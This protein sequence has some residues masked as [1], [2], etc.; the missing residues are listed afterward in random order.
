MRTLTCVV[1]DPPPLQG[2]PGPCG[3]AWRS[4][5][6]GPDA[7]WG[8]GAS[9]TPGCLPTRGLLPQLLEVQSRRPL[10]LWSR[11]HAGPQGT[12]GA[13]PARQAGDLS[14]P[15]EEAHLRGARRA[16]LRS[17]RDPCST[18]S[19]QRTNRLPAA[20]HN[21]HVRGSPCRLLG[22]SGQ[23]ATTDEGL[24]IGGVP[25]SDIRLWPLCVNARGHRLWA[26]P[27]SS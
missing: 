14:P 4:Q 5:R 10:A 17:C 1:P 23:S 7:G 8:S 15:T 3:Q 13:R 20:K 18:R 19:L 25:A 21:S 11:R 16:F 22:S 26:R 12:P 27:L 9:S 6:D 24:M 2:D